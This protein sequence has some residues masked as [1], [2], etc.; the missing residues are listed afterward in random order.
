MNG[1]EST[2]ATSSSAPPVHRP[3]GPLVPATGVLLGAFVDRTG[4]WQGNE[5]ALL[6][7]AA[8]EK[9]LRRRLTINHHFYAWSDT[10]PSGLEQADVAA[11]RVPLVSWQG[12]SL[13]KIT[14]GSQDDL[15]RTRARAVRALGRPM[16]LRWAWEMNG[17]WSPADGTHNNTPGTHDGPEKYVAAWRHIRTIFREEGATNAVW[18]WC[19]N[20]TD[21]PAE[22]WNT[23]AKYYPGDAWVDWVG[24]DTYNWG[25]LRT[26]STWQSLATGVKPFQEAY[27][28]RKPIMVAETSSAQDAGSKARW[29]EQLRR[30]VPTALPSVAAL[31]WFDVDKEEDWRID[32]APDVLAAVRSLAADPYFAAVPPP[33]SQA[34]PTSP[35]PPSA[36]P[37]P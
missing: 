17:N 8:R 25:K 34:S 28:D 11:G 31:V 18:V 2:P 13:R 32:S 1:R 30:E 16:F 26:W 15:I 12:T 6:E 33:V 35:T 24:V 14:D 21:T 20:A 4:S 37:S 5:A 23:A 36:S 27:G 22:P 3:T 10:F 7:V 19:P 29:V 9:L